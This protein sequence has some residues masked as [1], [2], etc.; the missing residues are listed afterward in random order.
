MFKYGFAGCIL[1]CALTARAG[2]IVDDLTQMED[3]RTAAQKLHDKQQLYHQR[4]SSS[5]PPAASAKYD[6]MTKAIAGRDAAQVV[7][8]MRQGNEVRL[9]QMGPKARQEFEAIRAKLKASR[10]KA[11][12]A[13]GGQNGY[14]TMM[15]AS[16]EKRVGVMLTRMEAD[17]HVVRGTDVHAFVQHRV[18]QIHHAAGTEQG[19]A[20]EKRVSADA[21]AYLK[22]MLARQGEYGILWQRAAEQRNDGQA[23]PMPVEA[24][25]DNWIVR[26]LAA[27]RTPDDVLPKFGGLDPAS[28]STVRAE[29]GDFL[30]QLRGTQRSVTQVYGPGAVVDASRVGVVDPRAYAN[31]KYDALINEATAFAAQVA[32]DPRMAGLR[33]SSGTATQAA[34]GPVSAQQGANAPAQDDKAQ[35]P[36]P[37]ERNHIPGM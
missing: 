15:T 13:Q 37:Q 7:D 6:D 19:L 23:P 29:V 2:E 14:Q 28:L 33:T 32:K 31:G 20:Q 11:N 24:M 30:G 1:A 22:T 36:E 27:A 25:K 26:R 4:I 3:P 10:Q 21:D 34:A 8:S 12:T 35:Q 17:G 18:Q 16:P 5:L 9:R